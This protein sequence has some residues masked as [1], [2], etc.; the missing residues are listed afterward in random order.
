VRTLLASLTLLVAA[1]PGTPSREATSPA[2]IGSRPAA[3]GGASTVRPSVSS[4]PAITITGDTVAINGTPLAL[5]PAW[6]DLQAILGEADRDLDLFNRMHVYDDLGIAVY[7][8]APDHPAAGRVIQI[9]LYFQPDASLPFMPTSLFTGALTIRGKAVPLD[10]TM[11]AIVAMFPAAVYDSDMDE[12]TLPV[13]G[14][15]V[16]FS[17]VEGGDRLHEVAVSFPED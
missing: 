8:G 11:P 13:G 10:A 12:Y 9:S 15:N 3:E 7:E 4:A 1:C 2:T 16:W 17:Q 5:R 14:E 6:S